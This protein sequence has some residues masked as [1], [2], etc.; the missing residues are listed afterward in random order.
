MTIVTEIGTRGRICDWRGCMRVAD[1]EVRTDVQLE[2]PHT[3][4]THF[5]W[6]CGD[7]VPRSALGVILSDAS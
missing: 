6:R 2:P 7:H 3:F 4:R 5:W 1:H